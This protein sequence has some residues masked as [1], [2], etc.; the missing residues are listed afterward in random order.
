MSSVARTRRLVLAMLAA[1][2]AALGSYRDADATKFLSWLLPFVQ[3][4]QQHMS[5]V[6]AAYLANL[7]G[8]LGAARSPVGVPAR[9]VTGGALRGVDPAE[10]YR[11]PFQQVWYQLS[12]G[13]PLAEAVQAGA[14]RLQAVAGTD[15]QLATTHTARAVLEQQPNIVGYRRVLTGAENCGLCVVASSQR[16]HEA[17]LMPIHPRCDCV[18][19]PIVGEH[20]PG[21]VINS[22]MLTTGHLP[23]SLNR[24]GVGVYSADHLLDVG[25][26][27]P[28]V[29]AAI[30]DTFG[31]SSADARTTV[32][33]RH[34]IT[35]H[36][37]G[38]IGP[39]LTVKGQK[40]TGPAAIH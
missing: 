25:N 29:H 35:V 28:D 22:A 5:T 40:F 16:Y 39:V 34:V 23:T 1:R 37:H 14:Q 24:Q 8:S 2:W 32:D 3:A 10:V 27:L 36:H 4:G 18:V 15:L 9:Q 21:Q 31:K 12:L 6:T 26:L 7:T 33:Y 13:K 19:A 20:D 17:D 11:R 38:E 30:R